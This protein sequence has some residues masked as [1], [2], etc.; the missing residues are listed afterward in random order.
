[1]GLYA[2]KDDLSVVV[3]EF[4]AILK[5]DLDIP[6]QGPGAIHQLIPVHLM[7]AGTSAVDS[8]MKSSN[9]LSKWP[10]E[11][12]RKLTDRPGAETLP[13]PAVALAANCSA[14][15]VLCT[16]GFDLKGG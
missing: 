1:M 6:P 5:N 15:Y 2:S 9:G 4:I 14:P 3:D 7:K 13:I 8:E 12:F 16:V 10:C 11:S